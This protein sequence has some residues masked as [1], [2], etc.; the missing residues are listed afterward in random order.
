MGNDHLSGHDKKADCSAGTGS[1]LFAGS[2]SV[3]VASLDALVEAGIDVS[4]VLTNPDQPKG[5]KGTPTPNDVKFRAQELQ[6]EVLESLEDLQTWASTPAGKS[7]RLGIAVAYG[8]ILKPDIL[9]L[10]ELG[11]INLHFSLLPELRG[12]SPV[13]TAILEGRSETGLTVFELR[14][15]LD[16]G[17]IVLQEMAQIENWTTSDELFEQ[18]SPQGAKVL[19]DATTQLLEGTATAQDQCEAHPEMTPTFTKKFLKTDARIDWSLPADRIVRHINAFS[20]NPGAWFVLVQEDKPPLRVVAI[21][22]CVPSDSSDSNA[23]G[24]VQ[25]LLVK[26]AG[27]GIMSAADW[28]RGLR[29]SFN[30]E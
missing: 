29:A 10:F 1:V 23:P 13:Q 25:L 24:G 2:A 12:A 9:N 26:P 21:K 16:D 17:P 7:T 8:K 30:L 15:G 27:K 5:R 18:L 22:A 28:F 3:S 4:A 14:P 19:V 11:W 6:I 20:S